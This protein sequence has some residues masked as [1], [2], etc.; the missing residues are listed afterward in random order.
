[1][2]IADTGIVIR[3][4]A[5]EISKIGRDTLGVRIMKF[6]DG[7]KVVSVSATPASADELEE[8]SEE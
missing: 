5:K 4:R 1:M 7:G 8:G 2:L 3:I 6:K